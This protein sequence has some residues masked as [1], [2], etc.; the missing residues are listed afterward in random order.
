MRN[1]RSILLNISS[2]LVMLRVRDAPRVEGHEEERVHDQAHCPI[3]LLGLGEGAVSALV[4]KDPDAGEDEALHGRVRSP[5]Q[6]SEIG[7]GELRDEREREDDK[8]GG[9]EVVSHDV[10][11][12][13][14]DRG[15]EAVCGDGIV[16]LLHG[17]VG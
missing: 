12:G 10:G 17:E 2:R 11:H 6:E 13:A 9:V 5:C 16:D 15:L 4:R 8:D 14:Q 3:Q 1:E 7:T